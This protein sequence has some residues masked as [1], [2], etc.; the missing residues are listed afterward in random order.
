MLQATGVGVATGLA[1]CL[2]DDDDDTLTIGHLAPLALDMGRGSERSAELAVEEVNDDGGI[3]DR[4]VELI[5]EDDE[6]LP[7]TAQ[8]EAERLI[9]REDADFLVGTFTS[10]STQGIMNLVGDADIP[11]F[12]SGSADPRTMQDHH[13]EDYDRYRNIFRSG[14]VN[15]DYQAEFLADYMEFLSDEHGWTQIAHIPEEAAWTASFSELVPGFLEER[16]LDVVMDIHLSRDTD[17]FVPVLDEVEDAGAEVLLKEFAH[18]PGPGMLS[19]WRENEYPFAQEGINVAS[20]S[21][22]F[23][24][25]TD[26]GCQYETTSESGGA[27]KA[28]ITDKSVSLGEA[29]QDR[30]ADEGR[31]TLPMYMGYNTYDAVHLYKDVVE[32]AGTADFENDLDDIVDA[33]LDSDFT[34]AAGQIQFHGPDH[35]YPHDVQAGVDLVPFPVTQWQAGEKEAVYPAQYAS[36]DHV[37][38]DWM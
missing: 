36:A 33:A 22:Q 13:G 17:D 1:G 20:M 31:P 35:E 38:P 30:F 15:S 32:R 14:P 6:G 2:G 23:W 5:S 12:I 25:D 18:I 4:E 24:D 3:L 8:T 37:V 26:G 29:Y 10:E 11:F 7:G 34:G 9:D 16:G 19:A 27:G 28:E 21:P